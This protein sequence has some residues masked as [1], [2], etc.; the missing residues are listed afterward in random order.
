MKNRD[1]I[2]IIL[3][4]NPRYYFYFLAQTAEPF[5]CEYC[6][7]EFRCKRRMKI[8]LKNRHWG[9]AQVCD[10]CGKTLISTEG[11]RRHKLTH[12]G[13]EEIEAAIKAGE[14][15]KAKEKKS[16]YRKNSRSHQCSH[17][18]KAFTTSSYL[19][20]H[21]SA[22]HLNKPFV[23]E[24]EGCGQTFNSS[25]TLQTHIR[26]VHREL[27]RDYECPECHKIFLNPSQLKY[28]RQG[29]HHVGPPML[30]SC[31]ICSKE[32]FS[33]GK[34][35]SHMSTHSEERSYQ[36]DQ[37]ERSYKTSGNLWTHKKRRH[38]HGRSQ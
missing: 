23:C 30:Y 38:G 24:E 7:K 3:C 27:K 22:I 29:V 26:K 28:H 37:C 19:R 17:C 15:P 4:P 10:I 33:R 2:Q 36:C 9:D 32:C 8:H 13:T 6:P 11:L 20:D 25:S 5:L 18:G 14:K 16:H 1:K 31:S 21:E 35:N 34:L 12:R